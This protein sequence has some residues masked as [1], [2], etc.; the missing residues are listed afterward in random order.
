M[1]KRSY[2]SQSTLNFPAPTTDTIVCH[3]DAAW[4][5]EHEVAG[6]AWVYSTSSSIEL[7]RGSSLQSAVASPL[8]AEALAIREALWHASAQSYKR[9]WLR[10]DSQWLIN[11]INL[12]LRL[13]ELYGILS[14]VDA[15]V[16]SDFLSVSFS[17]VS[18]NHN[19]PADFLAKACL[20]M[21]PSGL[22][23]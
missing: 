11:A 2:L 1:L 8:V 14:D 22:D 21:N 6:L 10:S 19:G 17:F 23:L 15:L 18:R 13:I 12:N 9:I 16:F 4:N 20:C 5:K 3:T 7:N